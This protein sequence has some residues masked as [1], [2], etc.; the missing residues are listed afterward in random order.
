MSLDILKGKTKAHQDL[1]N[2]MEDHCKELERIL[3]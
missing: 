3:D 2:C 1:A